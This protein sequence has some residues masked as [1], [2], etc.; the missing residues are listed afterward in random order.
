MKSCYFGGHLSFC[1]AS[2]KAD[3]QH[4]D[5]LAF[6]TTAVSQNTLKPQVKSHEAASMEYVVRCMMMR[7]LIQ[8]TPHLRDSIPCR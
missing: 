6:D 5:E 3:E 7:K 1:V 4:D 2:D 8:S